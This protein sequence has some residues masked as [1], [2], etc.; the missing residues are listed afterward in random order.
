[1]KFLLSDKTVL[2]AVLKSARDLEILRR[3]HWYRIPLLHLPKRRFRYLAFYEPTRLAGTGGQIRYYAKVKARYTR[4]RVQ[5]L[6]DESNHPRAADPYRRIR[7]GRIQKLR[8]PIRNTTPR[9]VSFGFTTH[10]QI[11]R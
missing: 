11:G 1:M 8:P 7:V 6:P 3:E 10:R 2:V 5:L 4:R 9:R